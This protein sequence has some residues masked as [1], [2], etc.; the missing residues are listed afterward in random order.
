MASHAAGNVGE[1]ILF[2]G[3]TTQIVGSADEDATVCV[4]S[5]PTKA[6]INSL[7]GGIVIQSWLWINDGHRIVDQLLNTVERLVL[8][9]G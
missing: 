6:G 7:R 4:I 9:H 3:K 1:F 5:R 8:G 2:F